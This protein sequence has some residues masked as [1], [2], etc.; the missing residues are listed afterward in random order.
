MRI[1]GHFPSSVNLKFKKF[2]QV[3]RKLALLPS[4]G[5]TTQPGQSG[6]VERAKL[7]PEI[8]ISSFQRTQL[9]M[10]AEATSETLF[11]KNLNSQMKETIQEYASV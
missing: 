6:M 3:F 10:E 4:S 1:L 5:Q 8:Y 11:L 7:N 9:M 2:K